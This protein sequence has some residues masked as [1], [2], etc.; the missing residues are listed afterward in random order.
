VAAWKDALLDQLL[1]AMRDEAVKLGSDLIR[2]GVDLARAR[3]AGEPTDRDI[4][5]HLAAVQ[6][7]EVG[8]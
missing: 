5:E 3:L 4:L 1:G 7:R 6:D 2:K 8:R